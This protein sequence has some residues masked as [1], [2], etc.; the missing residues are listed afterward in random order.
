MSIPDVVL[1]TIVEM[2]PPCCTWDEK[3]ALTFRNLYRQRTRK[4]I[5]SLNP[6]YP[7]SSFRT[8]GAYTI[9]GET[10]KMNLA[11]MKSY[12]PNTN[13]YK[14]LMKQW[15]D[16]TEHIVDAKGTREPVKT[17][18]SM[19]VMQKKIKTPTL[20]PPVKRQ[21]VSYSEYFTPSVLL[22][23][24]NK[25]APTFE[26]FLKSHTTNS[27]SSAVELVKQMTNKRHASL[28][29][30]DR[31]IATEAV[32]K[33]QAMAQRYYDKLCET[34]REVNDKIKQYEAFLK[35]ARIKPEIDHTDYTN[36]KDNIATG[37]L[38]KARMAKYR[39]KLFKE[40]QSY[41]VATVQRYRNT[42]KQ[43]E[44]DV[45]MNVRVLD[46][47]EGLKRATKVGG[48][49]VATQ[50]LIQSECEASDTIIAAVKKARARKARQDA[51]RRQA[52]EQQAYKNK[53]KVASDV[54]KQLQQKQLSSCRQWYGQASSIL[55][56]LLNDFPD[57]R[58]P[59]KVI[60]S[61]TFNGNTRRLVIEGGTNIKTNGF[62]DSLLNKETAEFECDY[63]RSP[64]LEQE[65]AR[66]KRSMQEM[67]NNPV[68]NPMTSGKKKKAESTEMNASQKATLKQMGKRKKIVAKKNSA[69][70]APAPAAPVAQAAP[71]PAAPEKTAPVA[72]EPVVQPPVSTV[73]NT[74]D[75]SA[76]VEVKKTETQE[77]EVISYQKYAPKLGA[78]LRTEKF[79]VNGSFYLENTS[80]AKT[81]KIVVDQ[82]LIYKLK[83]GESEMRWKTAGK[84]KD[85]NKK[86]ADDVDGI[87]KENSNKT[88]VYNINDG[89]PNT[90]TLE[91]EGIVY[92][93][94]DKDK[95]L[96]KNPSKGVPLR[97]IWIEPVV[98]T[99]GDVKGTV[100]SL[101]NAS[102]KPRRLQNRIQI[103]YDSMSEDDIVEIEKAMAQYDQKLEKT[104]S[105][106]DSESEQSLQSAAKSYD[107]SSDASMA[108]V[109]YDSSSDHSMERVSYDSSSDVSMSK[110]YDSQ[111]ET[112]PVK[113]R[114][115][116]DS[117]SEVSETE[118]DY[119]YDSS[120][121]VDES[122][123][124]MPY[125]SDSDN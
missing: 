105:D 12:G 26:K 18:F 107:S 15:K 101:T 117:S 111:S 113:T 34:R 106:Y 14:A 69:K 91:Y 104:V 83:E 99:Q 121:G 24:S 43:F 68:R 75:T 65:K 45:E 44:K 38:V 16:M 95:V 25:D 47:Q 66:V 57:G 46:Q 37:S 9:G 36:N 89:S 103:E 54:K 40:W 61:Y 86:T 122:D 74:D 112:E 70:T 73:N 50:Q 42:L 90:V 124:N 116:Y 8:G 59:R 7:F 21:R 81:R 88:Y 72:P 60:K 41:A 94:P 4:E 77:V 56:D 98:E 20:P 118:M 76:P 119:S 82:T 80:S 92:V 35:G 62:V 1:K 120:S 30:M 27:G 67:I 22:L 100:E 19:R 102:G 115:T 53:L 3:A 28:K 33:L 49:S 114:A 93:I 5:D 32:Q 31:A 64:A 108:K 55:S 84:G 29:S 48:V 109:S 58:V 87:W 123:S 71:V 125:I 10:I 23:A 63:A 39:R 96:L 13:E 52:Q 85:K 2:K 11:D 17:D 97:Y 51:A 78:Y 110:S 6:S 79:L